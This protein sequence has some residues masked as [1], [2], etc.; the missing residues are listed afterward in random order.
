MRGKHKELD[1][2]EALDLDKS[3]KQFR[4]SV[5]GKRLSGRPS[6]ERLSSLSRS[7]LV[8]NPSVSSLLTEDSD[9]SSASTKDRHGHEGLVKHVTAWLKQEKARR[10]SRKAKRMSS[11]KDIS[12]DSDVPAQTSTDQ[13][14]EPN[15]DQRRGSEASEGSVALEELANILGR[16]LSLKSTEGSPRER[17]KSHGRKLSAI[18][19]RQ[20]T[21]SSDTDYFEG[22]E[23][24]VP[25]S[26]AVLDNSKTMA[27]SGGG[28]ESSEEHVTSSREARKAKKEKEAWKIFKHEIVRLTHTLKLKGWRRV[29]LEQSGEI[30]VERLSGALTNAVYV[31]S[32]PT[33]V[34]H[35]GDQG[36][37]TPTP[38]NPPP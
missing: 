35:Q 19:K 27:Y 18:M 1:Q 11:T 16:T 20:S 29:P 4:A 21:V 2:S 9:M 14:H 7:S 23:E 15:A 5:G 33:D 8:G 30:D 37:A 10:T 38:K 3:L 6:L 13:T 28:P 12:R 36:S 24:L 25:S 17:K 34:H 26:D 32:P 31:V 22:A